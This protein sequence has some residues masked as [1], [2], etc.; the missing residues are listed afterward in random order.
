MNNH[1]CHVFE[2]FANI[3][4]FFL[5][6]SPGSMNSTCLNLASVKKKELQNSSFSENPSEPHLCDP[7]VCLF[8]SI[9]LLVFAV[10]SV[11]ENMQN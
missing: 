4:S 9:D 3:I 11:S 1:S 2:L 8:C 6:F 5:K 10:L 7:L